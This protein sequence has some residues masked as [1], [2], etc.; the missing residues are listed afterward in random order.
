[1]SK[2]VVFI[3]AI[4]GEY[5][6]TCKPFVQQTIDC[7][8]LCFTDNP[9]IKPNGWQVDI[10]PYHY[11]HRNKIDTGYY[12]NSVKKVPAIADL[13]EIVLPHDE[14][15]RKHA[16]TFRG[17]THPFALA[18]YYKQ[19]WHCIPRL[20]DYECVIWVDGT[21]EVKS[22]SMAE[23]MYEKIQNYKVVAWNHD[24]RKGKLINEV[25]ASLGMDKYESRTWNNRPQPLQDIARQYHEYIQDGYDE[26]F[27]ESV[28]REE[29]KGLID[30]FGVWVT[31]TLG[32]LN[33]SEEVKNFLDLWYLQTLKYTTQ[34]QVSFSKVVQDTK[35][36]PYT[37]PDEQIK[38]MPHWET[39]FFKVN[40]HG[41]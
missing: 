38:G 10:N 28:E 22:N 23:Y 6:K 27:W 20:K 35:I 1:M 24:W 5:E 30:H 25:Q 31:G 9:Y 33:H 41:N 19:S 37:Y 13:Y 12:V 16:E 39:T 11:T 17:N 7:D 8:F 21:I 36:I 32:F 2:K 26:N 15:R 14:Y 29:G 18:K 34:D 3:S 40:R 4:Y